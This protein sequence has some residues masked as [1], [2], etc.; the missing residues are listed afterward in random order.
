MRWTTWP[1]SSVGTPSELQ[2]CTFQSRY[3][4]PMNRKVHSHPASKL[5]MSSALASHM[6]SPSTVS[7]TIL[8]LAFFF[9]N[10]T[11]CSAKGPIWSFHHFFSLPSLFLAMARTSLLWKWDRS[12]YPVSQ[13][14][15]FR[16]LDTSNLTRGSLL[17]GPRRP[18]CGG[19]D[20]LAKKCV[21]NTP[22][23]VWP[24]PFLWQALNVGCSGFASGTSST[25]SHVGNTRCWCVLLSLMFSALT[26]GNSMVLKRPSPVG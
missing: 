24:R 6:I 9:S 15:I 16:S 19:G 1:F 14:I 20:R 4:S 13:I 12:W 25:I 8:L 7:V 18:F 23:V 5:S 11:M 21:S 22:S 17:G 10:C 3:R 26:T 2:L